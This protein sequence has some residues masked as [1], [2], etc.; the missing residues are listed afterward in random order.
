MQLSLGVENSLF[1]MGSA[2]ATDE[3][4]QCPKLRRSLVDVYIERTAAPHPNLFHVM[5]YVYEKAQ[6]QTSTRQLDGI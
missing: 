2:G 4:P 1:E 3:F 6:Y 5:Y